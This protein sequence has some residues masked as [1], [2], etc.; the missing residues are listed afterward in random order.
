MS[1]VQGFSALHSSLSQFTST[2]PWIFPPLFQIAPKQGGNRNRLLRPRSLRN[3]GGPTSGFHT[4]F[5]TGF[6]KDLRLLHNKGIQGG[7]LGYGLITDS[8]NLEHGSQ[9]KERFAQLSSNILIMLHRAGICK[10]DHFFFVIS[11]L[12]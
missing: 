6:L 4:I 7:T 3:K 11:T 1:P 5:K 2:H 10:L 9:R 12:Y 8:L